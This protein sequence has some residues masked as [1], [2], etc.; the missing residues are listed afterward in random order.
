MFQAMKKNGGI[1]ALFALL[2]TGLVAITHLLTEGRIAKQQEIELMD[3]LNQ[4][5]PAQSHDNVLYKSCTLVKDFP[6]LGTNDS[7]PAYIA[8]KDGKPVGIAI[9]AIAPDGYSGAIKLIVGLNMDGV[10][11]GVRV[12]QQNET[13]GLGDKIETSVSNWIY[14]FNGKKVKGENDP[15]WHVRKDGGE[16]DQFTGAT[17]TPR[18]VVK[19]V[20]NVSLF[21][22]QNKEKILNQ[23]LNCSGE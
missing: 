3:I 10:V 6:R 11:T 21:W 4:V 12:L 17:I 13:P 19:S 20:K 9:Q 7:E 14:S 1:L 22:D 2:A 15:A 23:P 18:A 5:V 8:T 16:F